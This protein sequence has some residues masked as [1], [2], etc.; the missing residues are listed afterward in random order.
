MKSRQ[1]RAPLARSWGDRGR[2]ALVPAA[3][4][5]AGGRRGGARWGGRRG[6]LG[7]GGGGPARSHSR[8]REQT[9]QHAP[10]FIFYHLAMQ[11]VLLNAAAAAGAK[12]HRN[13]TVREVKPGAVPTVVVEQDGRTEEIPAR[14][15]VGVDGRTSLVR[16]WAG[17]TV[18]QDPPRRLLAGVFFEG[19]RP[20]RARGQEHVGKAGDIGRRVRYGPATPAR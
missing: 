17:F 14:L 3:R 8:G 7:D 4:C 5:S 18:R 10:Q 16:K 19:P 12:V 13:A 20:E 15:V 1:P 9:A 11:E 6:S 2:A